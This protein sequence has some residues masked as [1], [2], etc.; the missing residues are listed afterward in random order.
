LKPKGETYFNDMDIQW[1]VCTVPV[2]WVVLIGV[3]AFYG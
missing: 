1:A 2:F 3:I